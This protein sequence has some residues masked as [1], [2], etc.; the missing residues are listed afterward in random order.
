MGIV[1]MILYGPVAVSID[2]DLGQKRYIMLISVHGL[3]RGKDLELGRDA[4][5]GGQTKY[6][7]EL[8]KALAQHPQV[9]QVDLVTRRVIDRKVSGDYARPIEELV[10]KARIVRINCGP[11]RYLPKESLW[12]HLDGMV[13]HMLDWLRSEGKVPDLIHGHYA[14]AGYVAARIS[15]LLDIPMAFT[16]HSLGRLKKQSLLAGGATEEQ[17]ER[18]YRLGRRIDAE[19]SA[20]DSATF[21]VASTQQEVEQQYDLYDQCDSRR[22][23]VIPPGVDL[24]RFAPPERGTPSSD[25]EEEIMRFLPSPEKPII[26]ALSRP[27]PKKNIPRLIEAFARHPKLREMANLVLVAGNRDDIA[28]LDR[29]ARET[30][31]RVLELIDKHDLYGS[32]AYP[33]HH[34]PD[35]V[36]EVYRLAA[37]KRGVFVNAALTEPFGLTLLEAAASGVPV[38]AT[39]DGGPREILAR[40]KN[41]LLVDPLDVKKLGQALAEAIEDQN[42]WKRWQRSGLRGV[43]RHYSWHA[44]VDSYMKMVGG[45]TK[46]KTSPRKVVKPAG[47]LLTADRLI[48]S[49]I[50]NTLVGKKEPLR[51]LLD[52]IRQAGSRL[53]FGVATGR[54]LDL[55][56]QVLEEHK[57]DA[58]DFFITSV[59]SSIH[60]GSGFIADR[61]WHHHID[62]RWRPER[63]REVALSFDALELQPE[64]GQDLFKVSFIVKEGYDFSPAELQA[65][66]RRAR[67][68]ART[69]FSHGTYLDLLPVRASKGLAVRYLAIRLGIPLDMVLVAGDSGN[70]E[71]MLRGN[72]LGVVVGNYDTELEQLR[73]EPRIYFSKETYAGGI[74]DGI[75]HY[76]FID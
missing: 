13:D 62:Y 36:P 45:V 65:A 7:V 59:G 55:A 42:Q 9:E 27:D 53:A 75:K 18:R 20:L 39:N 47:R 16:G 60:Y 24:E 10:P 12:P 8:A 1:R 19:E 34:R 28:D 44:H 63:L 22:M 4:D 5:T 37:R 72:T 64:E 40:C 70:D 43:E 21:V 25:I 74:L 46:P 23:R 30:W 68:Q 35:D 29:G 52:E 31:W 32:I 48:I 26:L 73:S 38:V 69:I 71:E 14:D 33:K 2:F 67:L 57:V 66:L 51:R 3:I 6:V 56:Q 54:R 15:G 58:P 41:G 17:L 76:G 11:D 49:D 61:G 50:D